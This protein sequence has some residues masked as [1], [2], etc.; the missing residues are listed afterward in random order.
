[1]SSLS[2]LLNPTKDMDDHDYATLPSMIEEDEDDSSAYPP[3]SPS[4]DGGGALLDE[5]A[6]YLHGI[7]NLAAPVQLLYSYFKEKGFHCIVVGRVVNLLTLGFTI[8]FSGFLLLCT[9]TGAPRSCAEASHETGEPATSFG[10]PPSPPLRRQSALTNF[11]VVV[12]LLS[13]CAGPGAW[14]TRGGPWPLWD[15]VLRSQAAAL[16]SRHQDHHWPGV[17]QSGAP[18]PPRACASC[19]I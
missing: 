10:T 2:E 7:Q 3:G 6:R 4:R 13:P 1:M 16:R 5:G 11:V 17:G 9:W 15:A 14:V 8:F 12:Y 19:R 18:R